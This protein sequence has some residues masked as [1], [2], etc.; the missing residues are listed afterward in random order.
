MPYADAKLTQ[1]G[2]DGATTTF[3]IQSN[4][5][6]IMAQQTDYCSNNLNIGSSCSD[7]LHLAVGR[8]Q[9][10]LP[11]LVIEF[12]YGSLASNQSHNGLAVLGMGFFGDDQDISLAD[13]FLDHGISP[14]PQGKVIAMA[15]ETLW[16]FDGLRDLNCLNGIPGCN[17]PQER[18][19][20]GPSV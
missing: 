3:S 13:S 5:L 6:A 11:T 10:N 16:H 7:R 19:G 9:F 12:L 15:E 14:D 4:N 1:L 17:Y 18:N 2:L 8:P 20:C